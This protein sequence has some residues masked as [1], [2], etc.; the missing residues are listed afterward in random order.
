MNK[1]NAKK[2]IVDGITFDSKK[3]ARYYMQL[4][5]LLKAKNI[6]ERVVKIELQPRFDI[7]VEGKQIAFYKADFRVTFADNRIEIIDVKGLKKGCAYQM[8]RLKKKLVEALY[9][10]EIIEK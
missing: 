9:N 2:T 4:K 1:F 8:F 5:M 3:E 6:K 7:K 10:I